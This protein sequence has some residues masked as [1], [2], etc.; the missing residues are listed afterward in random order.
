M[1]LTKH[2]HTVADIQGV[3][4]SIIET[5]ISNDRANFLKALLE[6]NR[7]N[8][9]IEE[10]KKKTD[11]APSLFTIGVT[12]I[13]FNPVIVV[14]MKKLKNQHGKI[15]TPNFWNQKTANETI[16]YWSVIS[17]KLIQLYTKPDY[18]LDVNY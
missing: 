10:E 6:L 12:D 18:K 3:R 14:Y 15:V 8:V 2:K 5:G 1:S 9:K 17:E 13:L 7:Y 16:P 4:C 11:D